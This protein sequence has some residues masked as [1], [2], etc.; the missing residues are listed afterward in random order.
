MSTWRRSAATSAS[1]LSVCVGS[2]VE[3]LAARRWSCGKATAGGAL[4]RKL[5]AI[6]HFVRLR[7]PALGEEGPDDVARAVRRHDKENGNDKRDRWWEDPSL[8]VDARAHRLC[9]GNASLGS[10]QH[11]PRP[12]ATRRQV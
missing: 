2:V 6:L 1:R 10:G 9:G 3:L 7:W 5:L 11:R 8:S 12:V 4:A